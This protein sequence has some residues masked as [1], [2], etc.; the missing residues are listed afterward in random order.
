M[1]NLRS[2][3]ECGL[4]L[5]NMCPMEDFQALERQVWVDLSTEVESLC[6]GLG[7]RGSV[8]L[9]GLEVKT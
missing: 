1:R 4:S 2:K 8:L 9:V 6:V 5:T 7:V 3:G